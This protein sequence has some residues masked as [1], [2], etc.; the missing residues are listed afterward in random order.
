[1]EPIREGQNLLED[2]HIIAASEGI[3]DI[4]SKQVRRRD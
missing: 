3:F 4:F 2:G 1:V